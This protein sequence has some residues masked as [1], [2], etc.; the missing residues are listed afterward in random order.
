MPRRRKDKAAL[1]NSE[2]LSPTM[3][4]WPLRTCSSM[5]LSLGSGTVAP[6]GGWDSAAVGPASTE[7]ASTP[8][9][10]RLLRVSLRLFKCEARR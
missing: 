4:R 3:R 10:P 2:S 8:T 6:Q 7:A 5:P 1:P 9:S